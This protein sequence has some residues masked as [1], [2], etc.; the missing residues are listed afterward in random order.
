MNYRTITCM[1]IAFLQAVI[2]IALHAQNRWEIAVMKNGE[3]SPSILI[4][5]GRKVNAENGKDYLRIYDN[6]Y[7]FKH[8]NSNGEVELQYGYRM[9]DKKIFIYDFDKKK[10]TVAFDFSLSVGDHF[11]TYNGMQWEVEVVKDTL[12]NVSFLGLGDSVSK[13]LLCVKTLDGTMTDQWLE[14]F[15]S[16]SN[17][18]MIR[19]MENV[20]FSHTLWMEYGLGD[21]LARDI[22][23]D[24]FYAHDSNM[25]NGDT[26]ADGQSF[27]KCYFENGNVMF[28]DV[29]WQWMHRE[30]NCFY[31]RSDDIYRFYGLEMEPLVD[32]GKKALRKDSFVFKGVPTPSSGQYTLHVGKDTYSTGIRPVISLPKTSHGIYDTQGRQLP[33]KPKR[34][35]YIQD[36]VKHSVK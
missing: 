8:E 14:D 31:R 25:L 26:Q 6:S 27:S 16:F 34:G 15:G 23:A 7:L 30:Y 35:L 11:T 10:E 2:A 5:Q 3:E 20:L 4:Y 29:Q 32:G 13:K 36:G 22:C 21:Y 9:D 1:I 28:E 17:H 12:V 33:A 18:F 19:D 24:P